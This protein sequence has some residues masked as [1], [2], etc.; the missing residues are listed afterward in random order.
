M[1]DTMSLPA[2]AFLDEAPAMV[3]IVSDKSNEVL[4]SAYFV[5][6]TSRFVRP[7]HDSESK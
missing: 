2:A 1:G 4:R 6:P 7:R 5:I 3:R